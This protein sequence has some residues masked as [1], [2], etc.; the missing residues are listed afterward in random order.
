MIKILK[1]YS[2]PEV[3]YINKVYTKDTYEEVRNQE[4]TKE[5]LLSI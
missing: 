5:L 4:R 1:I 3:P 2:Q